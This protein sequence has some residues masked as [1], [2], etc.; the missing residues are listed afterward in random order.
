MDCR[1]SAE[2]CRQLQAHTQDR[3]FRGLFY[4]SN[5]SR[6]TRLFKQ[7]EEEEAWQKDF[8]IN[9]DSFISIML[10][11]VSPVQTLFKEMFLFNIRGLY[12]L[13]STRY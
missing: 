13:S 10:E 6:E 3:H 4:W 1:Q 2:Y 9:L 11:P 5:H 8:N 7:E 12:T